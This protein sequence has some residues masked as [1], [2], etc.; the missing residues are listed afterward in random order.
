MYRTFLSF[1]IGIVLTFLSTVV[2]FVLLLLSRKSQF[3]VEHLYPISLLLTAGALCGYGLIVRARRLALQQ[4][5]SS[6]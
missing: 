5:V 3:P 2:M 6:E 1:K 4:F